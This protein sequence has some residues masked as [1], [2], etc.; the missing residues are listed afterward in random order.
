MAGEVSKTVAL[1]AGGDL[2]KT[3]EAVN[4]TM[5]N[6]QK[7]IM[8]M[9]KSFESFSGAIKSAS[10]NAK[11]LNKELDEQAKKEKAIYAARAKEREAARKEAKDDYANS[12]GTK[13]RENFGETSARNGFSA[14][15]L[16]S[17][18][19][20]AFRESSKY[21]FLKSR[22]G[23]QITDKENA[24]TN[25]EKRVTAAEARLRAAENMVVNPTDKDG[26][27]KKRSAIDR[28]KRGL[29][30]AEKGLIQS[31]ID[32]KNIEGK[33]DFAGQMFDAFYVTGR[34]AVKKLGQAFSATMKMMGLDFKNIWKGVIET[35]TK[36]LQTE[37][38]ASYNLGNSLFSNSAA[39]NQAMQYGL[40]NSQN[41]AF[42]QTRE[43]LNMKSDEDLMYMNASQKEM[44]TQLMNKYS[45]WYQQL[46]QSGMLRNVQEAQLELSMLKQEIA[47]KFLNWF[48]ENKEAIFTAIDLILKA[49]QVV[50]DI[51]LKILNAITI[52]KKYKNPFAKSSDAVNA[53]ISS[54]TTNKSI[55]MTLNNTNNASTTVNEAGLMD[56]LN[57]SNTT[58]YKTIGA[59]LDSKI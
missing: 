29:R 44:F 15:G 31:D 4:K 8:A 23:K 5:Q 2:Q 42:T 28:A 3:V 20:T 49:V 16:F 24:V 6:L 18:M 12:L 37:G 38:I 57:K 14:K 41:Y 59:I 40:N 25:A 13:F 19:G 34:N 32:L 22:Y 45:S 52:S 56:L 36:M 7:A 1:N 47:Y 11:S 39:R 51:I 54:P 46:E 33:R 27:A 17:S 43:M 10:K 55:T 9:T 48:A 21:S 58:T 50:A 53:G 26:E 30:S 35:I